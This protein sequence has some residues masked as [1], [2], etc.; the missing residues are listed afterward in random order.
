MKEAEVEL[1]GTSL[2]NVNEVLGVV[3]RFIGFDPL[4]TSLYSHLYKK[5]PL[6]PLAVSTVVSDLDGVDHIASLVV[7]SAERRGLRGRRISSH[8]H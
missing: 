4:L 7:T 5:T 2:K 3:Q 8:G 6:Y 1:V